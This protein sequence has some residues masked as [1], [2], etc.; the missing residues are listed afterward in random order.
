VLGTE[1]QVIAEYVNSGRVKIVFWPVLNHGN[2]SVVSTVAAHCIGRQD[3]DK[4]WEVHEIFFTNQRDLF[5]AGR[6]YYVDAAVA[7]GADQA[8]F[9]SCYDSEEALAEVRSL[10][11][12]RRQRGI[13]SQPYFDVAGTVFGGALPFESFAAVLDDALAATE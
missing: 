13:P 11:D 10:D 7:L 2:P 3:P 8:T 12:I 1:P 6:D 4:F 5:S 9:E